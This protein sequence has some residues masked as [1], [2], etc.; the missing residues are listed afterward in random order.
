[1]VGTNAGIRGFSLWGIRS[2]ALVFETCF[3]GT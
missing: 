1:M 3:L 2:L